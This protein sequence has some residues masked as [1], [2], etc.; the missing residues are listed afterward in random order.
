[1]LTDFFSV[2]TVFL[3]R[4]FVLL[5]MELATRRVI[6]F[7]VTE[8]PDA[9][10]VSQQ[11]RNVQ[12]GAER[13]GCARKIPDPRSRPQVRRRLRPR[14]QGR[15]HGRDSDSDRGAQGKR[16]RRAPDRL[17]PAGMSRLAPDPQSSPPRTRPDRL[18]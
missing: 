7:A 16:T 2:D 4:L 8:R 3:R 17:D 11:A 15:W 1:M 13:A 6:W 12:L 14:L 5:Y 10:W 9:S 18:V